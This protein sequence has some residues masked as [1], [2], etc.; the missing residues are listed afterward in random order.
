M[1]VDSTVM[2]APYVS[3]LTSLPL[4]VQNRNVLLKIN[5]MKVQREKMALNVKI[6]SMFLIL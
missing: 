2:Y 1:R 4:A 3:K 6:S 5:S